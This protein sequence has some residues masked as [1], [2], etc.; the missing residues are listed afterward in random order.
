MTRVWWSGAICACAGSVMVD[1]RFFMTASHTPTNFGSCRLQSVCYV[2]VDGRTD[3]RTDG[4]TDGG[5]GS[6]P[7]VAW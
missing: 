3:G 4:W 7:V 1:A 5:R 2:R 6:G